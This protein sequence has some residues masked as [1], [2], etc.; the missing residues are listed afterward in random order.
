MVEIN[1]GNVPP[2]FAHDVAMSTITKTKKTK[3][4]N[5]KKEAFTELVFIDAVRKSAL[6]RIVLPMSVLEDMPQMISE[7]V[8]R[9]KEDLRSKE[10]P[11]SLKE[12]QEKTEVKTTGGSYV[13]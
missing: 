9:I 1:L 13:G 8:K 5:I 3:K 10:I 4:G 6:A 12:E 2:I 11:K 7:S